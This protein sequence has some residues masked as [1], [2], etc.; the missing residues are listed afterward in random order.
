MAQAKL[1]APKDEGQVRGDEGPLFVAA[2]PAQ[3]AAAV[4]R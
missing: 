3:P 1:V 2:H 4:T